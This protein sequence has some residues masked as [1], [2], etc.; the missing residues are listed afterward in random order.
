MPAAMK[1]ARVLAAKSP[2]I[3]RGAKWS[4]NEVE[5]MLDFEQAY[6]AIESRLTVGWFQSEDQHEAGRSVI[7]KRPPKFVGK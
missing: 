2:L 6:R 5:K 7:Q 1:L 4:A 3:L